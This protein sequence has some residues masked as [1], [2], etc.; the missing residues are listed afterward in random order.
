MQLF[1]SYC[2]NELCDY[3]LTHDRNHVLHSD[4]SNSFCYFILLEKSVRCSMLSKLLQIKTKYIVLY[5][6]V[7]SQVFVKITI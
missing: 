6:V 4:N 1:V 7:D 2:G 5:P 3:N